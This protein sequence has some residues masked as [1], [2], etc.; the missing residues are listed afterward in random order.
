MKSI[1]MRPAI[2]FFA[3]TLLLTSLSLGDQANIPLKNGSFERPAMKE[4]YASY[5]HLGD[6]LRDSYLD[7]PC[8][9]LRNPPSNSALIPSDGKNYV[10]PK[11]AVLYQIPTT[12]EAGKIYTFSLDV[13][14]YSSY[15]GTYDMSMSVR[16]ATEPYY[17]EVAQAAAASQSTNPLVNSW[18]TVSIQLDSSAHTEWVGLPLMLKIQANNCAIDNAQLTKTA[19]NIVNLTMN[20]PSLAAYSVE[21][22][23]GVHDFENGDTITVKANRYLDGDDAYI[24]DHW[25]GDVDFPNQATTTITLNSSKTI[26]ATYT[27]AKTQQDWDVKSDT[28]VATDALG[29]ELPGYDT[30]GPPRDGKISAIYYLF[31]LDSESRM[32]HH[33]YDV[34][35]LLDEN[36]TDPAWG[37]RWDFHHWGEAE[38]G[39]YKSVDE[40]VMRKHAYMLANSGIDLLVL[41]AT[42]ISTYPTQ[43]FILCETLQELKDR[44]EQVPQICFWVLPTLVQNLYNDF[45]SK[46]YFSD[47][48]FQWNGKPLL[49]PVQWQMA[50]FGEFSSTIKNFFTIRPM[51]DHEEGQDIWSAGHY[52]P[53]DYGWHDGADKPEQTS[54]TVA[55][56]AS[57][58]VGRSYSNGTQPAIDQYHLTGTESEGYFVEEQWSRALELDP[59]IV[60]IAEWN[61]WIAMR[62]V[63]PEDQEEGITH[64]L[65]E[66]LVDGSSWFVDQYNAEYSRDIEPMKGGYGDSYYYQMI[67]KIRQFEGVRPPEVT[68]DAQTIT[69]D[70]D[71]AEWQNTTPEYRDHLDDTLHRDELGWGDFMRYTNFT[72]R[73]DFVASKVARDDSYVYFY[74][75]TMHDITPYS[76]SNWMMLFIDSD[77]N[78]STGW[79]GYDYLVNMSPTSSTTTT[80]MSTASGWDWTTTNSSISYRVSGNE[81]EIAIPRADINQGSGEAPVKLDL[82]WTDNIQEYDEIVEFS[83]SGDSAPDRRF[84]YRYDSTN[85]V[86]TACEE[87]AENAQT[88]LADIDNNCKVDLGDLALFVSDWM[89]EISLSQTAIAIT[90]P[91]FENPTLSLGVTH[92]GAIGWQDVIDSQVVTY[93][94]GNASV[95]DNCL[96]INAFA[97]GIYQPLSE[98]VSANTTYTLSADVYV[99]SYS[100]PPAWDSETAWI[101]L[102]IQTQ[103]GCVLGQYGNSHD[104]ESLSDFPTDTWHNI[105]CQW[106]S[107]NQPNMIGEDLQVFSFA[108]NAYIDNVNLTKSNNAGEG[109]FDSNGIVNNGDLTEFAQNWLSEYAPDFMPTVLFQDDFEDGLS[110]K[111]NGWSIISTDSHSGSYSLSC[112]QCS[113]DLTS[114]IFDT[115][116]AEAIVISFKYKISSYISTYDYVYLQLFNGSA[117]ENVFTLGT[118]PANKNVWMYYNESFSKDSYPEFFRTDFE[119]KIAGSGINGSSEY[120]NIDDFSISINQ[121]SSISLQLC[122]VVTSAID[123]TA[124]Q[125]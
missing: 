17:I 97:G 29:R 107:S 85:A 3:I 8:P 14:K 100:G 116:G 6:W 82:H 92:A 58:N 44:G 88:L 87:M 26:T 104:T 115:S 54:V 32:Q 101:N 49:L 70:G 34:T 78:N 74:V 65:G 61:E 77:Q 25:E 76:D 122:V 89:D 121:S 47:L 19:N 62:F 80:L 48:W 110:G 90:N 53:Q 38:L 52:Y 16:D 55:R 108:A 59:D 86:S 60:W 118:Y 71:F 56:H 30:C 95:G 7:E 12:I 23:A 114:N 94:P 105:E 109:D 96:S 18:Q 11:N 5:K 67:G 39:Y 125:N 27:I 15:A 28:W 22:S 69:I 124:T 57:R 36:P 41:E 93:N 72:G 91:S 123:V 79:E 10:W 117:F 66:T 51:W 50:E 1:I 31:W 81:L 9:E 113:T 45:Y 68:S 111:W 64:F 73:N 106:N 43:Y 35:K 75:R 33:P 13:S 120:V 102:A 2:A 42:N 4:G 63:Y 37:N 46:N 21:P 24:F 40:Y 20:A 84:N 83:I 119:I 112:N 103:D 99:P 98:S